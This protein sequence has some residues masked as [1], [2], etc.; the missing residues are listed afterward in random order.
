MFVGVVKRIKRKTVLR[1]RH[2]P[3]MIVLT[4]DN[5][6]LAVENLLDPDPDPGMK[7]REAEESG[8]GNRRNHCRSCFTNRNISFGSINADFECTD[9]L[10]L[11]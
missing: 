4:H 9:S 11:K 2:S 10:N 3:I 6:S 8:E 7:I 5:L 1:G